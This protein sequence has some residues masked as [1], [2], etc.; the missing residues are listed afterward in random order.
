[1]TQEISQEKVQEL[2]KIIKDGLEK[3]EQKPERDHD[4]FYLD[5]ANQNKKVM[6]KYV[7]RRIK[8]YK[9]GRIKARNFL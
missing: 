3:M 9:C 5:D 1:M 7:K 6:G 2:N 4:F 8:P